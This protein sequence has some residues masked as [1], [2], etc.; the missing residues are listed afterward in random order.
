MVLNPDI[1]RKVQNEVD[2][3]VGQDRLPRLSDMPSLPYTEAV[4]KETLRWNAVLP[5][6]N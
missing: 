4:L 5:L 2:S 6:G 3:I 1:F